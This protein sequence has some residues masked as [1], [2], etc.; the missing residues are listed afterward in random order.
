MN[1]N[2]QLNIGCNEILFTKTNSVNLDIFG[3]T[4]STYLNY[5][6]IANIDNGTCNNN[7]CGGGD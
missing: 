7:Y 2:L 6:P 1:D 5:N 4:D 3:C